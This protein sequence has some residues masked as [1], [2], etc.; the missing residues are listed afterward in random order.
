MIT[1]GLSTKPDDSLCTAF[2]GEKST[3]AQV[4]QYDAD[5]V[6]SLASSAP[7]SPRVHRLTTACNRLG[8]MLNRLFVKR[9]IILLHQFYQK[10]PKNFLVKNVP[11]DFADVARAK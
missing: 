3:Y 4:Q 10:V 7:L 5:W 9:H 11:F 2:A 6:E 1:K 8:K